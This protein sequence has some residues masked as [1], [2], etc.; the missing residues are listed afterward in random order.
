VLIYSDDNNDF[1]DITI[2]DKKFSLVLGE[3]SPI[4]PVKVWGFFHETS[5]RLF[6]KIAY[7]IDLEIHGGALCC[8]NFYW[9]YFWELP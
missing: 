8:I 3:R 2:N 5:L 4:K 6:P 9:L 1:W 7:I